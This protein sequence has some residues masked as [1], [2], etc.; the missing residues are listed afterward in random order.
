MLDLAAQRER[1]TVSD[2][3]VKQDFHARIKATKQIDG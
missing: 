2:S 1:W 3:A